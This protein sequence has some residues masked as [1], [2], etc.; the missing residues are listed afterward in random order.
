MPAVAGA[1]TSS[2]LGGAAAAGMNALWDNGRPGYYA[3]VEGTVWTQQQRP[4]RST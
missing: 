2:I 4:N 3:P 1:F